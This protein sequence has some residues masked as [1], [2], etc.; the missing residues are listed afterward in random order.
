[1]K[2]KRTNYV[3]PRMCF[4]LLRIMRLITVFILFTVLTVH[5][6]SYSQQTQLSF[7]FK[8][9]SIADVL[10]HI[11]EESEFYFFYK[12]NELH[13]DRLIDI[14]VSDENINT[15][16]NR[17][18]E[19]T[20]L[21]YSLI[22]RY[23]VISEESDSNSQSGNLQQKTVTGKITD[24]SGFP[25]PGVTVVIKGT[26][27]GIISDVNGIYSLANVPSDATLVFSFVGMKTQEIS[28]AGKTTIDVTMA[29]D[30]IGIEEVVAIGYGTMKKSDLTY[31]VAKVD[32]ASLTNRPV[33]RVDALMVGQMAGV[34]VTQSSGHPGKAPIIRV[35]GVGSISAGNSPLYVIDGF[36]IEDED[37][38]ANLSMNSVESIEVLK[39]AAAA[40]IYGSRGGKWSCN[41]YHQIGQGR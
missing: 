24:S 41:Y 18:L 25:L 30:A 36:A 8:Q 16:L 6:K 5:A 28:A 20:N 11:E 27:Q 3:L 32:G 7:S 37:I 26:T 31:S 38:I 9:T 1:M 19:G 34:Q 17:I 13:A 23:V 2:K 4:K 21:T 10:A 14:K 29:E 35:R 12:E 33:A 15:I 22:D 40:S 39:D